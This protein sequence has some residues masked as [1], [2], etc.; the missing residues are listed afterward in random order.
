MVYRN[1]RVQVFIRTALLVA[2]TFLLVYLSYRP[3]FRV[4]ALIVVAAIIAQIISFFRIVDHTNRRVAKL[5]DSIRHSDFTSGF[6]DREMGKSFAALSKAL[7]EVI[8]EFNK[9]NALRE[10]HYNYLQTVVQHATIGIISYRKDGKIDIHN[11]AV[12][13]MFRINVLRDIRDLASVHPDFPEILAGIRAGD[14]HLLRV[15]IKD[16]LLQ[17]SIRAT[18]FRMRG[19][20]FVLISLQNIHNELEQKEIESWQKLIR[21]LTHE[22]M[23]S[24]TPISSLASTVKQMLV[25]E[26]GNLISDVDEETLDSIKL[27]FQTIEGRSR[28]L[29]NF[30]EAYRSLTRIPKPNFR[31][32]EVR[33]L[34]NHLE[35]LMHPRLKEHGILCRKSIEPS[36]LR[37]TADPDLLDQV[38]INM[39]MNSVDALNGRESPTI[40]ITAGQTEQG[41]V[42]ISISDNGVGISP[43]I[44]ENIFLPFYT[45]KKQG[46][47]IGLSLS[48]QIMHLHK[49]KIVVKS[50]IG[51]GSTF[52]LLF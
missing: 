21:V 41:R 40:S 33:E 25:D 23:N 35:Q 22:M 26:D 15:F 51:Q 45:S 42:A 39:V 50:E 38:L 46:S 27:A 49:G 44:I 30:V 1:F 13:R 34:F 47:G 36:D 3:T 9:T 29:L 11:Q 28:G 43:D 24:I 20:E 10:E 7:N 12:K 8:M 16:E 18:E 31:Y 37:I 52:T 2:S 6:T 4:S 14:D 5:L 32:L 19:E 17:V 48:R